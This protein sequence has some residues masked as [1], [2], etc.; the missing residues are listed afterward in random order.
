M[1]YIPIYLKLII[2][3]KIYDK[4]QTKLEE[5]LKKKNLSKESLSNYLGV[6]EEKEYSLLKN[7]VDRLKLTVKFVN[8][9]Q[10]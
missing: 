4:L 5:S 7:L 2:K 6:Y 1:Y 8:K 10:F 9:S 3:Y